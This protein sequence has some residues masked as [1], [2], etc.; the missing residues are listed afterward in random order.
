MNRRY[1][2]YQFE[3]R[4]FLEDTSYGQDEQVF[5]TLP[6]RPF[7]SALLEWCRH[8]SRNQTKCKS[9]RLHIGREEKKMMGVQDQT[10]DTSELYIMDS[11]LQNHS[12]RDC[13]GGISMPAQI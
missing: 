6:S 4:V 5:D 8:G 12:T 13:G 10:Q 9:E 1:E 11:L 2:G 3:S 7:G